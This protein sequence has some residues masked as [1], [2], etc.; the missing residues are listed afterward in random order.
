MKRIAALFLA[1][2]LC[3]GLAVPA[4]AEEEANISL[5]TPENSGIISESESVD[6]KLVGFARSGS[7]DSHITYG[8]YEPNP[9]YMEDFEGWD[10]FYTPFVPKGMDIVVTGAAA[11]DVVLQAFSAKD[12]E[13]GPFEE[14]PEGGTYFF[15][16]L[17]AW[18]D[19]EDVSLAP[20][21]MDDPMSFA[22]DDPKDGKHHVS[23]HV[24]AADAGF[25]T[26]EDGNVVLDS[27]RLYALFG[28]CDLLKVM[29]AD[30][31]W[32]AMYRLSG[33]PALISDVFTDVDAGTWYS[34]PVAWAWQ[35]DIAGGKTETS[36][37]PGDDCTQAQ[38]LTFL[39][40]AEREEQVK[41]TAKDMELA[42]RWAKEKGMIDDSFDGSAPCTRATA[43]SYIW[44]AFDK[45][46]AAASSF[47]DVEAGA[48]YAGAVSWAVEKGVT[49]GSNAEGTTFSPDTVCTRGH[50]A[51]FLYRAYN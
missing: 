40:R 2:A 19:G 8:T 25:Q 44:Q 3:L 33:E 20:L 43:V 41:P 10:D 47:T 12:M 51:T 11:E 37:A 7:N 9:D 42:V 21:D 18:E 29:A 46:S 23:G 5:V 14:V 22:Y 17:F 26:D 13:K 38:I 24:T 16:R 45:P 4:F 6:L 49:A 36:F 32:M 28:E 34:D 39:Y 35:N 15:Y 30:F 31:S 50:I 1:L 27:Q 48:D